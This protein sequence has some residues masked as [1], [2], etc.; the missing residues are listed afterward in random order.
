MSEEQPKSVSDRAQGL[1][2]VACI[3]FIL[4]VGVAMFA[5][6]PDLS[7]LFSKPVGS[8]DTTDPDFGKINV[9]TADKEELMLLTGIGEVMA[10]RI[11]DYREQYGPFTEVEDLLNV[12]GIGD[13]KLEI[14][15]EQIVL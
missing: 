5:S 3:A 4:V 6:V 10:Q 9:N 11:L 15:R 13:A 8:A 2:A 12:N 7:P 14:L 1:L